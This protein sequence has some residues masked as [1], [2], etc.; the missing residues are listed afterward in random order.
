MRYRLL[1][2]S[3]ALV[4]GMMSG[5]AFAEER[6]VQNPGQESVHSIFVMGNG[7]RP[8]HG[9]PCD[10]EF[11]AELKDKTPWPFENVGFV[12]YPHRV[13]ALADVYAQNIAFIK[14]HIVP[15][16]PGLVF[17]GAT[18]QHGDVTFRPEDGPTDLGIAEPFNKPSIERQ[19]NLLTENGIVPAR[20]LSLAGMIQEQL[21]A[22]AEKNG[23]VTGLK[24]N[25]EGPIRG[26]HTMVK[27]NYDQ[28]GVRDYL[29][30]TF[31]I[32]SRDT[33]YRYYWMDNWVA[34]DPAMNPLVYK[35]VREGA[36]AAGAPVI[37]RSG[38]GPAQVGLTDIIAPAPDIQHA[39]THVTGIFNSRAVEPFVRYCPNA[40]KLGFDDFY[41][42]APFS[43][44]QARFLATMHGLPGIEVTVTE[45]EFFKTPLDRIAMIQ[46]ILPLPCPGP[47]Q[48]AAPKNPHVWIEKIHREFG[49]WSVAG[50]STM[51]HSRSASCSSAW[52]TRG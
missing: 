47:L 46:Q 12:Y 25:S 5:E 20:H 15:Y 32:L 18:V 22:D 28:P 39:W 48:D 40:F 42:N 24:H 1:M 35:A 21:P 23:W 9:Y 41:I 27:P 13:E 49:D 34:E 50:F 31:A 17:S 4:A 38:A 10:V 52:P 29:R 44:D 51:R 26:G 14:Q 33:G 8:E 6:A 3:G 36:K 7:V 45:G 16:A 30:E 43:R 19:V 11:H 2:A 37:L